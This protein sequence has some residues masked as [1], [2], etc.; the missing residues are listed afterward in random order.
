MIVAN[1]GDRAAPSVAPEGALTS[2]DDATHHSGQKKA[3]VL[4]CHDTLL[5]ALGRLLI[6][7]FAELGF[8]CYASENRSLGRG[9]TS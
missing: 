2:F 1:S 5:R 7:G 9:A 6:G 4:G 8:R 3:S